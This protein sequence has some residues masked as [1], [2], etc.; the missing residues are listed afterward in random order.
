M[1]AAA[2]L[3]HLSPDSSGTSL[4]E[5]RSLWPSFLSG[6]ALP[7]PAN[8]N[9]EI[10]HASAFPS[11]PTSSSVPATS[12]MSAANRATPTGPRLHDYSIPSS[13]NGTS[14]LT[15]L[16]PGLIGVPTGPS[17]PATNT[18]ALRTTP[19]SLPV[20]VPNANT[21]RQS[22]YGS[23]GGKSEPWGSPTSSH[24]AHNSYHSPPVS[25]S[26]SKSYSDGTG[27]WSLPRSSVR[28]M[29]RDSR[30]R[31][32]SASASGSKSDEEPVEMDDND[33]F[34][35][36]GR[37]GYSFRGRTGGKTGWKREDD[38]MSLGFSVR[39]EDEEEEERRGGK[40]TE[41]EAWDGMDMD[42]VMD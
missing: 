29:S 27:G 25:H 3:S 26:Y 23:I 30:S 4:P 31:S 21:Y 17:E 10:P 22:N 9:M 34:S 14:G 37:Y 12:L 32:P 16:R 40:E 24:Y 28:S 8:A 42:M 18:S 7:P 41:E 33:L 15:Q 39:E 2:I 11:H 6:G 20:P 1:Q 13:V 38:D 36:N 5:D 35:G 19:R